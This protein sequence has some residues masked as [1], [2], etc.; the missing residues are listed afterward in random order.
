LKVIERIIRMTTVAKA[1]LVQAMASGPLSRVLGWW[2][3]L[4]AL[5]DRLQPAAALLARAYVA[6]AF[7]KSGLTKLRD[8]DITLALFQDEYKV[9]LLPPELAA[10][11][12]T[13]GELVLPLLLLLGLGG[14]LGALGLSVVN[15]V[16]VLSLAEIAP[17]ALQQHITWGVLL[18]GLAVF[19]SGHWSLDKLAQ[20]RWPAFRSPV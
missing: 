13:A 5:L 18:A 15:G 12:G 16:A 6:E 19:G 4:H 9:P 8:W 3:G 1:I 2:H 11:M 14:R 20:R 7:F 17:A 10:V